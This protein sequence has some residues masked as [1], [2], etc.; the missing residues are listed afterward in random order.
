MDASEGNSEGSFIVQEIS[1]KATFF[2]F[3]TSYP[4]GLNWYLADWPVHKAINPKE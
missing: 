1:K 4:K 3:D 2:R